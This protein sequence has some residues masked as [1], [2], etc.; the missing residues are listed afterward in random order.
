MIRPDHSS[1]NS[2]QATKKIFMV[3]MLLFPALTSATEGTKD[4]CSKSQPGYLN[5]LLNSF[6]GYDDS[7]LD[8]RA[9]ILSRLSRTSKSADDYYHESQQTDPIYREALGANM[10]KYVSD[11]ELKT[12]GLKSPKM[13]SYQVVG[14][15]NASRPKSSGTLNMGE[16]YKTASGFESTGS[17]TK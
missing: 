11:S 9:C 1:Q 15:G 6:K 8:Y 12:I 10:V 17:Q 7:L 13:Q 2:I 3:S 14:G 4:N 16:P 5:Q